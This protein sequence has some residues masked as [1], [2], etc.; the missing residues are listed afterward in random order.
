M[1]NGRWLL[2]KLNLEAH[3]SRAPP[4]KDLPREVRA[5]IKISRIPKNMHPEGAADR[6]RAK[7]EALGHTWDC[8]S[9]TAYID[10]AQGHDGIATAAMMSSDSEKTISA[11]SVKKIKSA[12]RIEMVAI[13][14]P[15]TWNLKVTV[16][17]DS[18]AACRNFEAGSVG[19]VAARLAR[20]HPPKS[21]HVVWTSDYIRRRGNEAA[22]ATAQG[23]LPKRAS[24]PAATTLTTRHHTPND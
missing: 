6:R 12:T 21:V 23:L 10:A 1:A 14:L 13:A 15:I 17:T 16:L 5:K 3:G 4:S 11:A 19:H 24:P 2:G 22:H 20:E 8:R 9:G 18:R 7:S